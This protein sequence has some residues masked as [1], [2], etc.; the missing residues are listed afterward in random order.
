MG[1]AFKNLVFGDDARERIQRG[2]NI[3]ADAVKVTMGPRGQNVIIE[4]ES[5]P[6]HLTKDGVSVAQAI[7]LR[8]RFENLGAQMVKEA[9]QRSAEIAGDG[10]TTAT[11]LAQELY[12]EGLKMISAGFEQSEV[13]KGINDAA[14]H[15]IQAVVDLSSPIESDDDIIHV[16]TISANGDRTIGE[17]IARALTAVGRDGTVTVEEAKGFDSSLD[18]VDGTQISRGY[19]S[20]YFVTNQDKLLCELDNPYIVLIN[21]TVSSIKELLPL[22]ERMHNEKRSI[23]LIADDLE[24][25]A[26]QA[27]S[28]NKLKGVLS[29]CAIKA[30]EFGDT[31]V[32]TFDDLSL[33][34]GAT[35]TNSA[36]LEA[37]KSYESMTLA[38]CKKAIISKTSTT[39]VGCRPPR[40]DLLAERV[41][42]LKDRLTDPSLQAPERESVQRRLSRISGGVAVLR[43]G[44]STEIE[45]KERKDRVDDALHATQAAIEEGIV[46]GGGTALIR[47]SKSLDKLVQ[48]DNESYNCG[49]RI[50]RSACESPL[51]QIIMNA[52]G[53]PDIILERVK[54]LKGGMG[55]DVRA[56]TYKDL[57]VS[58]IIDPTKVVKS[59]VKHASSVACNLLSIGA[60][61]T[62]DTGPLVES[63]D[64]N[65]T[66]LF[67]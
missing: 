37:G 33:L 67:G 35:V 34:T 23:L 25:E 46:P 3:L 10:T 60:A 58:G 42:S 62:H 11:V 6:P 28:V 48:K 57:I 59:A 56:E 38:S 45:L 4:R 66:L 26:L 1:T 61:V 9:A 5:G 22:L 65:N 36:T 54:K 16:G 30:P 19:L 49:V 40:V 44:G 39:L 63:G 18:V 64:E 17:L 13:C 32:H 53:A 12:N 8:D 14:Q 52:G 24:A 15:V 31:R 41:K 51:R 43:V 2:V 27:L 29:V 20:P 47:A 55:Y 7:D 50:M 21:K